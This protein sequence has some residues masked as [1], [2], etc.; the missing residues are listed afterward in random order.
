[1]LSVI[2]TLGTFDEIYVM[3]SGGPGHRDHGARVPRVAADV[4]DRARSDR[5]P[6]SGSSLMLIIFAVTFAINKL[7]ERGVDDVNT[8]ASRTQVIAQLRAC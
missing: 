6:R 2:G 7:M 4:P 3:T 8:D 1:M 5:P